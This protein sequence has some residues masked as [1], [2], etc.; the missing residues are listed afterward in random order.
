MKNNRF[1]IARLGQFF[2]VWDATRTWPT[3]LTD[4]GTAANIDNPQERRFFQLPLEEAKA[5]SAK[6]NA[7]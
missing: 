6:L 1:D 2:Y 4:Q 5:L 7:R 3:P